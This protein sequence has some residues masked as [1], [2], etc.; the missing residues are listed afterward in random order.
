MQPAFAEQLTAKISCRRRCHV[1]M[2]FGHSLP[3]SFAICYARQGN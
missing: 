1:T 2:T 3:S